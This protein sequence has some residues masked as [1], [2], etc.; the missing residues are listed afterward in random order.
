MH[1]VARLSREQERLCNP[2]DTST[3][4]SGGLSMAVLYLFTL[5]AVK[6]GVGLAAP[7]ER[8]ILQHPAPTSLSSQALSL[9]DQGLAGWV[10]ERKQV[11]GPGCV[12]SLQQC[13]AEPFYARV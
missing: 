8:N 7:V 11:G 5:S 6:S 1:S 3:V 9:G 10:T 13:L 12:C 2:V 4:P